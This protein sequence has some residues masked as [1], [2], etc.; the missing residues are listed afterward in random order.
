MKQVSIGHL[1]FS[2]IVCGTNPF[3]G[4]SHFSAA[5]NAEYLG[6]FDDPAIERTIQALPRAWGSTP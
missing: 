4:H 2:K 5:R 1:S 3:Y 6:R